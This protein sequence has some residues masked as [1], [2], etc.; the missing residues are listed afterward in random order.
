MEDRV[1]NGLA[2]PEQKAAHDCIALSVC[3][4]RAAAL[5]TC[6]VL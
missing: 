2:Y 3:R 4:A 1:T 5:H 6:T